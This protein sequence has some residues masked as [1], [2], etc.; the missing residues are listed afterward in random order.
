V[1]GDEIA[2]ATLGNAYVS[3]ASLRIR[4]RDTVRRLAAGEQLG[5]EVS[6]DKILL[7]QTEHLVNDAVREL[8]TAGFTLGDGAGEEYE[9]SEWYYSRASSVYGGAVEVQ[10]NIVAERV[11]GLPRELKHG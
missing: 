5:P 3:L 7:S 2:A 10:K 11:L 9:R 4:S 1:P 8:H 6:I